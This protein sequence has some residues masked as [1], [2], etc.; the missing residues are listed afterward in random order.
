MSKN[1]KFKEYVSDFETTV[2]DDQDITLVWAT[3][4]VPIEQIDPNAVKIHHSIEEWFDE[5]IE[6]S[7]ENKIINFHNLKF[8]G[9]FILFY[10]L[11]SLN[12]VYKLAIDY[13]NDDKTDGDMLSI[14]DMGNHTFTTCI[15]NMG[16]WYFIRIK[17]KKGKIIEIRDSLKLLPFSVKKIGKDFKTKYQKLEMEYE[18]KRYP[19]CLITKEEED[20]IKNDVLVVAEALYKLKYEN[21][22]NKITIGSCALNEFIKL[23]GGKKKFIFNFPDLTKYELKKEFKYNNADEYIRQS[24]KGG[25]CYVNEY[26][27]NNNEIPKI[28]YN[29]ITADVNSLYPSMMMS[30]RIYPYGEPKFWSGNYIPKECLNENIVFIIRIKCR[31]YLKDKFLPFIQIKNSYKYKA[32]EY[33]KTSDYYDYKTKK[34]YKQIKN[35]ISNEIEEVIPELT[36]TD[37]DFKLLLKHY[38]VKDLEILDGCYFKGIKGNVL[39]DNYITK[40]RNMKINAKNPTERQLSKLMLNSLYGKFGS[41]INSSFKVPYIE[42]NKLKFYTI[43]AYN[44]TPVYVALASFIT[45]YARNFTIEAAQKNFDHFIYADTDSIHLFDIKSD[46][47]KGITIHPKNFSCWALENSWDKAVFI[48]QKT[49]VEHNIEADLEKIEPYYNVKCAGMSETCKLLFRESLGE[50]IIKDKD[51]NK[52]TND[53]KNFLKKERTLQDFKLGLKIPGKL[54]PKQIKGGTLL[55]KTD[56]TMR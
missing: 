19:G 39:F 8:D 7:N 34:Y 15:S 11:N 55:V 13:Y 14:K 16:Q 42:D 27:K 54:M 50:K 12:D 46:E 4:T 56:F 24:Y 45:S 3:A 23:Y 32:N 6:K 18:G 38:D 37:I 2:Y 41:N 20:Y 35:K 53:E 9:S 52:L 17:N 30:D 49:Y 31:F 25:W 40:Y 21:G 5:V 51:K 33:L 43:I 48:R 22:M 10:L 36:L 26:F 28:F 29:G 47:I 44:K 1:I